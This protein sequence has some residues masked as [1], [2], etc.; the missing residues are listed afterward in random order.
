MTP[1]VNDIFGIILFLICVLG[2]I[3]FCI[4]VLR[5]RFKKTKPLP[6]WNFDDINQIPTSKIKTLNGFIY[7]TK[8]F[9]SFC[10]AEV[11]YEAR[12]HC[13]RMEFVEINYIVDGFLYAEVTREKNKTYRGCAYND[14]PIIRK[15]VSTIELPLLEEHENFVTERIEFFSLEALDLHVK[16][17][18]LYATAKQAE[19]AVIQTELQMWSSNGSY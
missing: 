5:S 3:V 18:S 4:L 16:R 11:G 13:G 6:N 17:P 14:L 8:Q 9:C 19:E 10:T 15:R 2:T 12:Q 7:R 1:T